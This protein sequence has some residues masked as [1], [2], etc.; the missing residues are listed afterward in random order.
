MSDAAYVKRCKTCGGID[1][2]IVDLP[3]M[4][5]SIAG[6]FRRAAK[7]RVWVERVS[8]DEVRAGNWCECHEKRRGRAEQPELSLEP[9]KVTA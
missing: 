1:A 8:C 2:A 7:A 3:D 5:A 9:K 4:A 6:L